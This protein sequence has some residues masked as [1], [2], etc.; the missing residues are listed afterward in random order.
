MRNSAEKMFDVNKI[1]HGII[2]YGLI[3]FLPYFRYL[4]LFHLY[5][6]TG[7]NGNDDYFSSSLT[8]KLETN[9]CNA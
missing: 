7:F 2:V 4:F 6:Y 9:V 3:L 5:S 1:W 8:N